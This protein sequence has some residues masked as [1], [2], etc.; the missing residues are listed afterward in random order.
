MVKRDGPVAV[1]GDPDPALLRGLEAVAV[2]LHRVGVCEDDAM[3]DSA[4]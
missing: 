1:E 4:W 3:R 2:E